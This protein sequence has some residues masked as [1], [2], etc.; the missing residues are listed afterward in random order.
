MCADC[1]VSMTAG[2]LIRAALNGGESQLGLAKRL[3]GTSSDADQEVRRW[4]YIVMR[5][6]K[7]GEPQDSNIPRIAEVLQGSDPVDLRKART[8]RADRLAALEDAVSAVLEGQQE[9]L[10]GQDKLVRLFAE[11]QEMLDARLP[12]ST[13]KRRRAQ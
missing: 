4:R 3:A 13:R 5:A 2:D 9:A 7:G 1:A 11:L 8:A 12:A 6:S 10:K